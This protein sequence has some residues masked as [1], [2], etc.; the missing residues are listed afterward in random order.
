MGQQPADGLPGQV[1]QVQQPVD[2]NTYNQQ[3]QPAVDPGQGQDAGAGALGQPGLVQGD[4]GQLGVQP[5][6]GGVQ[7]AEGGGAPDGPL[8]RDQIQAPEAPRVVPAAPDQHQAPQGQEGAL[9]PPGVPGVGRPPNEVN[10]EEGLLRAGPAGDHIDVDDNQDDDAGA[11]Y[12]D[13]RQDN[14]N[15]NDGDGDEDGDDYGDNA[16]APAA[17]DQVGRPD[18]GDA[19]D[20]ALDTDPDNPDAAGPGVQ[21]NDGDDDDNEYE[22]PTK[23]DNGNDDNNNYDP[24]NNAHPQDDNEEDADANDDPAGRT[25]GRRQPSRC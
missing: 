5:A 13:G 14:A 8:S 25:H 1:G 7:P 12:K 9:Q 4:Q 23:V 2:Q 19:P 11:D 3:Q 21:I 17:D 6:E 22:D 20:N 10:N 24:N 15:G 18:G 16:A